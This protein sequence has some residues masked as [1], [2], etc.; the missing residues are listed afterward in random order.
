MEFCS[1]VTVVTREKIAEPSVRAEVRA[2]TLTPLTG[3]T[4]S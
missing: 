1:P 3:L 4:R 2:G